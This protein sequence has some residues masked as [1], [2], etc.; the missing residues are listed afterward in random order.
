MS[1]VAP[2]A[3][4]A[5][6]AVTD[7][8]LGRP[9]NPAHQSPRT[10]QRGLP[11][12]RRALRL[13]EFVVLYAG[14]PLLIDWFYVPQVLI[15]LLLVS[16]SACIVVL[17]RDPAF[18]R[19][20]LTVGPSP[21]RANLWPMFL[22]FTAAVIVGIFVVSTEYPAQFFDL[23]RTKPLLWLAVM[24][25]YP[26][27]SV[28]PQE[29]MYRTF[30]MHRYR[31][32]FPSRWMM[33]VASASAFSFCHILFN[34]WMPLALTFLGGLLFAFTYDRTRSTLL[35]SLEHALYGCFIFTVGLGDFFYLSTARA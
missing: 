8:S 13:A 3:E 19:S 20:Q 6:T 33:I 4:L 28:Y 31:A 5:E 27:L 16:M 23:P 21:S 1:D 2:N 11:A 32:V 24:I 10:G 26:L 35:A 25:L 15:P 7:R 14:G 22:V 30:L 29:V 17:R 9:A 18:D 12:G 34:H